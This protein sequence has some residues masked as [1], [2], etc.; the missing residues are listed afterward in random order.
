[1]IRSAFTMRWGSIAIWISSACLAYLH[2][3]PVGHNAVLLPVLATMGVVAAVT[4]V[5]RRSWPARPVLV[6]IGAIIAVGVF[7]TVL[8]LGNPGV[9]NGTLVWILAPA[10]YGLWVASGDKRLL[11]ALFLT[12]A[13]FTT[14]ISVAILLYIGGKLGLIPQLIPLILQDQGGFSFDTLGQNSTSISFYGLSTL[15]GAAPLWLTA[16]VLPRHPLLPHKALSIVAAVTATVATMVSGRAALTVVTLV[17]PAVV[18]VVWRVIT[19]SKPRSRLRA[20]APFAAVAA[21]AGLIGVLAATGNTNV[22][23]AFARVVSTVTGE[24]QT[25]SDRIRDVQA[26]RLIDEWS[27]SPLIGH[28]FGATIDGYVRSAGR[29]WDFELQYNRLRRRHG[30]A[31]QPRHDAG[32]ARRRVGRDRDGRREREQPV[33][34]GARAHVGRLSRADGGERIAAGSWQHLAEPAISASICLNARLNV[35]FP[36]EVVRSR[37]RFD[38]SRSWLSGRGCGGRIGGGED[39]QS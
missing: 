22:T 33:P 25:A 39:C 8:G 2:V 14:V 29:P 13:I 37:S 17:V 30:S 20:A 21:V 35:D 7:G 32:G 34:P 24:G 4:V 31:P 18:W 23:N 5:A 36:Q 27:T 38:P 11:K 19:P 3:R 1:M 10:L 15:V 6:A 12:S 16:S 28:G 26:S 9:F